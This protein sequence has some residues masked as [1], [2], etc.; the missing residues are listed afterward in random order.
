M[1]LPDRA[2]AFEALA[3]MLKIRPL[4]S[5]AWCNGIIRPVPNRHFPLH[6]IFH[7]LS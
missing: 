3:D 6:E 5:R 2:T 4:P 7:R 1:N